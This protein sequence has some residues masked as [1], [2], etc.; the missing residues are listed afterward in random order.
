MSADERARDRQTDNLICKDTDPK[1][2]TLTG[3]GGNKKYPDKEEEQVLGPSLILQVEFGKRRHY[4]QLRSNLNG[5]KNYV[6][7]PSP[8]ALYSLS[9]RGRVYFEP[10]RN[11]N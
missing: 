9:N 6:S 11:N 10:Q 4:D 8:Y 7:N 5:Y 2:K 3:L 1:L